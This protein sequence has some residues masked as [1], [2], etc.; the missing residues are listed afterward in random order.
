MLSVYPL[1][2]IFKNVRS[3][4][5]LLCTGELMELRRTTMGSHIHCLSS[6]C[7]LLPIV[8]C[9]LV[10]RRRLGNSVMH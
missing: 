4:N 8:D 1:K 5:I 3:R 9:S 10:F 7:L 6:S 2:A